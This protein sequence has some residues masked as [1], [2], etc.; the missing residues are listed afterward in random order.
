VFTAA[1]HWSISWARLIDSAYSNAS[2][3]WL[4]TSFTFS[5]AMLTYRASLKCLYFAGCGVK[6]LYQLLLSIPCPINLNLS[7]NIWKRSSPHHEGIGR[8]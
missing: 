7:D 4:R 1:R 5:S 6:N 2:S 8:E 3:V